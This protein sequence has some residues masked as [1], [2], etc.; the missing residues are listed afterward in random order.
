MMTRSERKLLLTALTLALALATWMLGPLLKPKPPQGSAGCDAA[1]WNHVYRPQ[2]LEIIEECKTVE[3]VIEKVLREAD[4]DLQIRLDVEDKSLLNERNFSGQHGM[5][6]LEPICQK[7][8]TQANAIEPCRNY[9]G[10]FFEVR[11]GMRVRVTGAFVLDHDHG[12][13]EIHPVTSIVPIP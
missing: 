13:R 11:A 12:W 2:R 7:R 5:L 1:L 3:G 9:A 8:I 4:G 10:P 6:V